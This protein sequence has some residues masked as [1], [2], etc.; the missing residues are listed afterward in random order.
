[1]YQT[2]E[3]D[4]RSFLYGESIFTTMRIYQGKP[5]FL[6]DHLDRLKKGIDFLY[7]QKIDWDLKIEILEIAEKNPN[8]ILRVTLYKE[9]A[10]GG[11]LDQSGPLKVAYKLT[12][13]TEELFPPKG[14]VKIFIAES[15]LT[16]TILPPYLKNSDYTLAICEKKKAIEKG[17]DD[18]LFLDIEN[19]V[20]EST[21]SNILFKKGDLFYAPAPSSICL[22]GITTVK[23]CNG[24]ER[25][26]HTIIHKELPLDDIADMESCWLVNSV[27][28]IS[29]IE[30]IDR[31]EYEID[32]KWNKQLRE[33]LIREANYE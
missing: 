23:L 32:E 11:F 30:N 13:F 22:A 12:E 24:L 6:D 3:H 5:L 29:P 7:N 14:A 25:D 4:N 33:L 18:C 2:T 15:R 16:K 10:P 26:N 21:T 9:S 31:I 17:G 8:S 27:F 1:M 28:G 20:T 19:N